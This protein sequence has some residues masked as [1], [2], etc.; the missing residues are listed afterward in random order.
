MFFTDAIGKMIWNFIHTAVKNDIL[1]MCT[2][3]IELINNGTSTFFENDI[4]K[5]FLEF[6]KWAN[7]IVFAIAFLFMLFDL[8]EEHAGQKDVDYSVMFGNCIK[9]LIFCQFN[10]E[11]AKMSMLI[12]NVFTS[13]LNFNVQFDPQTAAQSF[14]I[15][16]ASPAFEILL[17]LAVLI[18]IIVFFVMS[19]MRYGAMFVH[20]LSSSL[21][22]S[23]ILRGD[24]TSIGAWLRQ[25]VAIC[26]TYMLQY[27]TFYAGLYYIASENILM[28]AIMWAGMASC[29]KILDKFGYSTGTRGFFGATGKIASSGISLGLRLASKV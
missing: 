7:F 3:M 16:Y 29:K 19:V 1:D 22:I 20:I 15:D 23:D 8:A 27:L 4:I 14:T 12:A 5:T 26:V 17:L 28:W 18:G 6:S 2:K 13:K 25:M 24:T 21:Y 11:I 10:A 9:A